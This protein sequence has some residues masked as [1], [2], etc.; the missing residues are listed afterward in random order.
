MPEPGAA[1]V[2]AAVLQ[3][4]GPAPAAPPPEAAQIVPATV[5]GGAAEDAGNCYDPAARRA[6]AEGRLEIV[7][8][9]QADGSVG[10]IEFPPGT[11]AWQ[12]STARC[13]VG[14]ATFTPGTRDGVAV[15][16]RVRVPV[17][18]TLPDDDPERPHELTYP[19]LISSPDDIE[20]AYRTCYP[21]NE[22][23]LAQPKYRVTVNE[24]GRATDIEL[25]DSSGLD[26]MDV[27]GRCMLEHF[28]F[29]PMRRDREAL[30]ATF[31]LPVILR[32][33]K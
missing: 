2:L 12:E 18:F 16:S 31:V 25:V 22:V 14:L 19:K 13:L 29:E 11:E 17:N 27:A 21:P 20:D 33:A 30:R 1:L 28:R 10:N 3:A 9:V 15:A 6:G 8:T 24:H 32:P 5:R 4:A 26:A 7:V 23:T